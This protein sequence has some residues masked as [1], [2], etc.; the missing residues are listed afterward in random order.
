[1][2][3]LNFFWCDDAVEDGNYNETE[4]IEAIQV[5]CGQASKAR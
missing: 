4:Q 5:E 3:M 2:E 1:M